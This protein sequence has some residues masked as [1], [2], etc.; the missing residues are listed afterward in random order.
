[1]PPPLDLPVKPPFP[2]QGKTTLHNHITCPR[3]SHWALFSN[4]VVIRSVAHTTKGR[5]PGMRESGL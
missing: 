4:Y 3:D 1:M 5:V 2:S